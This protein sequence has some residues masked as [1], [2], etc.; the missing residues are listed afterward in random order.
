MYNIETLHTEKEYERKKWRKI[1]FEIK[2]KA[3][4][5]AISVKVASLFSYARS[6][7]Y[8]QN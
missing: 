2:K 1:L 5:P 4:I 7:A 3:Q 8:T 6:E